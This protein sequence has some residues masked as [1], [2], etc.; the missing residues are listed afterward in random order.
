MS[1]P[2]GT[3]AAT[4]APR[5]VSSSSSQRDTT[6]FVSPSRYVQNSLGWPCPGLK[7]LDEIELHSLLLSQQIHCNSRLP[8]CSYDCVC[9]RHMPRIDPWDHDPRG[10]GFE[11]EP[12][13]HPVT[14]PHLSIPAD[15]IRLVV[16]HSIQ[17]KRM[18]DG[19][20]MPPR[21]QEVRIGIHHDVAAHRPPCGKRQDERHSHEA[22]PW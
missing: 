14:S 7:A 22:S 18:H 15:S 8:C 1:M 6:M 2:L 21:C 10:V 12:R 19:H 3:T 9:V 17:G 5:C 4:G 11:S 13:R 20:V 16:V